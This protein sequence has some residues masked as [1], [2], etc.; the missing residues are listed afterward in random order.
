MQT[1]LVLVV[2]GAGYG[3]TTASR[4]LVDHAEAPVGWLSLDQDDD[5]P[6]AFV[7]ALAYS[8]SRLSDATELLSRAPPTSGRDG[9]PSDTRARRSGASGRSSGCLIIEDVHTIVTPSVLDI[10]DLFLDSVPSGSHVVLTSR[11]PPGIRTTR[12]LLGGEITEVGPRLAFTHEESV[13]FLEPPFRTSMSRTWTSCPGRWGL[14]AGLQLAVLAQSSGAGRELVGL[15]ASAPHTVDYLTQEFL[16]GLP[17]DE[18]TFLLRSSVLGPFSGEMADF[19]LEQTHS[20]ERLRRLVR[21]GNAFVMSQHGGLIRYHPLFAEF[22]EAE[23]AAVLP[24]DPPGLHRRAVE[25]HEQHREHEAAMGHALAT[26]DAELATNVMFRR[27]G[28]LVADGKLTTLERWLDAI[29]QI[30]GQPDSP[31]LALARAWLAYMRNQRSDFERWLA[32]AASSEYEGVLPDGSSSLEVAVAALEMVA[33]L[34]GS[35]EPRCRRAS[36]A[37]PVPEEARTGA[38][39]PFTRRSLRTSPGRSPT[40]P[41]RWNRQSSTHGGSRSAR[42][43]TGAPG[44]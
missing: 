14:P 29:A 11:A 30:G 36:C 25:W 38:R 1:P 23:L 5:D 17:D 26:R 34:V 4:Q 24:A 13:T 10:F 44:C 27:F 20:T 18:R 12:R 32:I 22:L 8:L 42:G 37:K 40:Q 15:L 2:A 19:V 41:R 35:S 6:V 28:K 7:R 39:P 9:A 3:K 43:S 33:G 21:S 31:L 16:R